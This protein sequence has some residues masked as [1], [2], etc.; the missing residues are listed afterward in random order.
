MENS[1]KSEKKSYVFALAITNIY[2]KY[3]FIEFKIQQNKGI[4][5]TRDWQDDGTYISITSHN[6]LLIDDK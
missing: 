1:T 5:G 2:F 6:F 3:H 4:Y